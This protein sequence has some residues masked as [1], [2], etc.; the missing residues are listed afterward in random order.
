MFV[1]LLSLGAASFDADLSIHQAFEA[2]L[3]S[4]VADPES[5]EIVDIMSKITDAEKDLAYTIALDAFAGPS[6]ASDEEVCA[7]SFVGVDKFPGCTATCIATGVLCAT[8]LTAQFGPWIG[9]LLAAAV[10]TP[11]QTT[12]IWGCGSSVRS[13]LPAGYNIN[14]CNENASEAACTN[15]AFRVAHID[16]VVKNTGSSTEHKLRYHDN[17]QVEKLVLRFEYKDRDG[18]I[19]IKEGR[20]W[21]CIEDARRLSDRLADMTGLT[22]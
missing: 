14:V 1:T 8:G 4:G 21:F 10:C 18:N 12:C 13:K 6:I 2:A 15:G 7:L 9:G 11:V 22:W 17:Q 20:R 19:S 16:E 5:G 3:N